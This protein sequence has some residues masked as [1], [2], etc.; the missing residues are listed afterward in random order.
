MIK[1]KTA[2]I[3]AN[4]DW[5]D[6]AE[7]PKSIS[8]LPEAFAVA[9][10]LFTANKNKNFD[11][12]VKLLTPFL[13]GRFL[14]INLDN[15]EEIF[16]DP[17]GFGIPESISK[18]IRIVGIKFSKRVFPICRVEAVFDVPI[19]GQFDETDMANWQDENSSLTDAVT[20]AWNVD[21]TDATEDLDFTSGSNSGVE[22][23]VMDNYPF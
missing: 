1:N 10:Q 17:E 3:Y 9:K 11:E 14:P 2:I 15:W 19:T 18:K 5:F 8:E 16:A 13:E 7:E 6:V 12:I 23:V 21:R 4:M 22:C 20:F